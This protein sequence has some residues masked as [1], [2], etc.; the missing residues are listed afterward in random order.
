MVR[1]RK[2]GSVSGLLQV[3]VRS[4]QGAAGYQVWKRTLPQ[5][6]RANV[7]AHYVAVTEGFLQMQ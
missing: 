4:P 2:R 3:P 1:V 7:R 5:R 6:S